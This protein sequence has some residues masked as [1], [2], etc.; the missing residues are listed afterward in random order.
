MWRGLF[1][2]KSPEDVPIG[3]ITNGVHILTWLSA[4]I[5]QLYQTH[6]GTDWTARASV[7]ATWQ[8]IY[9]VENAEVWEVKSVLKARMLR[10]V[11]H[12]VHRMESRLE[13]PCSDTPILHPDAL[14][15]GFGRRFVPYKRPDLVFR[16]LDRLAAIV[17]H[18]H[19]PVNLIF[20][21]RA[22]PADVP[23]KELIQRV[24]RLKDDPRFHGRIVFLENYDIHVGRLLYHGVD[25]WLN[26][27]RRPL[28]A[29]GTSGMKV[30]FN[31]G[32]HISVLDGWWAEAFDGK[33]GF[34]IGNGETHVDD[35]IQDERDAEALYQT[36]ENEVVPLFYARDGH[37]VPNGWID[38]VKRSLATLTWRFSADRMVKDYVDDVYLPTALGQSSRM[39]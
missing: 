26:N 12:R 8:A 5:D 35:A 25:A 6:L 36:L 15:I 7:P 11:Q 17:N 20:A 14:T 21:G 29:C 27:P 31:G 10:F 28:E 19:R 33:N 39:R 2:K 34:A 24:N 37:G 18:P 9:N 13:L 38:R 1:G 30:A 4:D 23:G 16:D 22:H 32:L 3:H